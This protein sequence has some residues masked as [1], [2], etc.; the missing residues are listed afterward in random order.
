V[1]RPTRAR[2]A[3]VLGAL[4]VLLVTLTVGAP[5]PGADAAGGVKVAVTSL[6]P[7][8]AAPGAT[9]T[10][11][12]T[13]T[14]N[15]DQVVRD[16]SIRLRF[17]NTH[18]NSRAE[19]AAVMAGQVASRD[20]E[21]LVEA[22]LIDLAPGGS[23]SFTLHQAL[24]E[25]PSLTEFGVYVLGLEVVGTRGSST[26]R[27]S[28]TRTLLPWVPAPTD[29]SPT[30]FSWVW[31]LVDAPV[32]QADGRFVDDSLAAD[33]AI[34]G[35]LDR[36]VQAGA[37]L[38]NGAA[39]TWAIDPDL[40]D[41]V[42][43]MADENGYLV[44]TSGDTSVPGGG[45]ALAQQWLDRLRTATAGAD[46]LALPYADPDVAALVHNGQPRHAAEAR[47]IG[48][49]TLAALLPSASVT[50][51]IAWPVDG[52]LDRDTLDSLSR[53]GVSS[54]VLDGRALPTTVDLA[55]TPSGRARLKSTT[56][57]VAA[58][59]A[60]PALV[61][62]LAR[63]RANASAPVLSAQRILA[64]TAMITAELPSTGTART[65]VAMPPRR[66]DPPQEFLD[67]LADLASAPWAAPVS[68][69]VLAATDPPEVDRGRLRYPR[70][71]SRTEL[72]VIYLRALD[73]QHGKI[74]NFA[75]VLTDP[76]QPVPGTGTPLIPGMENSLRRLESSWWRGRDD[77]RGIR[78]DRDKDYLKN[79]RGSVKVQPGSFTFGS[80]SGMIPL[81]L[82]NDL[83]QE[84]VVV[85]RLEPQ[86]PR[87]K[88]GAVEPQPIGPKQKIQVN[89]P[90]TAIAGGPVVVVATLH[91]RDGALY[92]Q[93]VQLR[94]NVTQIGTVALVIT[95][96]AAVVL[97]L[98][99]GIR[100]VRR[101]RAARRTRPPG[102]G[103]PAPAD[104]TTGVTTP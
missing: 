76:N 88:L 81:T 21:V 52:Y 68:L 50:D 100:V 16:V 104:E 25:V 53:A 18:L 70:A 27:V 6:F 34:G 47:Q 87:L 97:F 84:V 85:L 64:E 13:V 12:G 65:I 39:V 36:L 62:L 41:T 101:L 42:A 91:T 75:G 37:R 49:E 17:S 69:R 78:L 35:R 99:A 28:I 55:Y 79:Q 2:R 3:G 31:P 26:G 40:V 51:D 45:G 22:P 54:T 24:S 60:D 44:A 32:R 30:G 33:L 92:G 102:P 72:P 11:A 67:Q 4:A 74:D 5:P 23:T 8:V 38:G 77:A 103:E 73:T 1:N 7:G 93:P 43:D 61:D 66:W 46:V 19:L 9:L 14:N 86:T 83:P 80:K 57:R 56:G 10:V 82:V 98:A 15:G 63:S 95:V 20:G 90:A 89:V 58:L 94:V 29:I 71:Q 59:L 96:A 48:A